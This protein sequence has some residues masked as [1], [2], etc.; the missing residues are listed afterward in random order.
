MICSFFQLLKNDS[1]TALSQHLGLLLYGT[2]PYTGCEGIMALAERLEARVTA[3]D[4]ELLQEAA[5]AKGLTLTAFVTSSAREAA[6][7]VLREQHVIDLG[8]RDQRAFAEALLETP[9]PNERLR[10]IARRPGFRSR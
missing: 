8:R 6:L 5:A 3:E 9:T 1:P 10:E 4:K 7:K 2:L